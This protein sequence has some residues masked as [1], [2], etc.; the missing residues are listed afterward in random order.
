MTFKIPNTK[1]NLVSMVRH[2]GYR[3]Q[4][5]TQ[6]GELNCVRPFGGDYPRFHLYIKEQAGEFV[7][8]LHL[9]QKRPSY[10]GATAHSGEYDSDVVRDEAE[11]IKNTAK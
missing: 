10:E 9:N 5:Y 8:N 3:P 4:G 1:E 7:F 6:E 2:L 11:R